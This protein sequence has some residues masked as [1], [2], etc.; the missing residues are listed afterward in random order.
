[1]STTADRAERWMEVALG[2]K[3]KNLS[4]WGFNV[5]ADGDKIYSYGHHFMMAKVMRTKS[6]KPSFVLINGDLYSSSTSAHQNMVRGVVNRSP[7]DS[8]IVP[9]SAIRSSKIDDF[10]IKPIEIRPDRTV[11]N[12]KSSKDK[13]KGEHTLID[14][15]DKRQYIQN[16]HGHWI[17]NHDW[18]ANT[19][20]NPWAKDPEEV[21]VNHTWK[22]RLQPDGTW[23]WNASY[24]RLGDSLFSAK[25]EGKRKKF[26][27]SFDYQEGALYF[28]CELP[29]CS[30]KTVDEAFEVLKPQPVKDA[31][32][33]GLEVVRQGDLFAIPTSLSTKEVK[34]LT[35]YGKGMIV[36]RPFVLNTN[37]EAT[38]VMFASRD[39]VYAKGC[40]YHNPSFRASDHR[41]QKLGDGKTWH[42]LYRNTVPQSIPDRIGRVTSVW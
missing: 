10:S 7:L 5:F 20:E 40:L 23:K 18:V 42:I 8:I 2:K 34:S 29:R 30:A 12:W 27:S 9:F 11:D 3:E 4:R 33:S 36:K 6:G 1:M 41:R 31:I 17:L 22:A 25:V 19:S 37:H 16:D 15:N 14:P 28:L 39:R 32:E 38:H 26:L 21:W 13:P 35:P 24:H